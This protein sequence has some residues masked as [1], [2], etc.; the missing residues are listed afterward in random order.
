MSSKFRL[1]VLLF[2]AAT[3]IFS[4]AFGPSLQ[5]SAQADQCYG[6]NADDCALAK[7]AMEPGTL[8]K[9]SSFNMDY[10]L[11]ITASGTQDS[12][13]DLSVKGTGP[14]SLDVAALEG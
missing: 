4:A 3:L 11:T 1:T 7:S 14:F 9:L 12:D 6:L 10:E 8:A 13:V 5:V 2:I